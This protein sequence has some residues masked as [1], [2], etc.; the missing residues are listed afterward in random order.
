[1]LD[2]NSQTLNSFLSRPKRENRKGTIKKKK[3][4]KNT[5]MELTRHQRNSWSSATKILLPISTIHVEF[6]SYPWLAK[7]DTHVLWVC[8]VIKAVWRRSRCSHYNFTGV[9]HSMIDFLQ[10]LEHEIFL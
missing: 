6:S 4:K 10:E 3:K 8:P 1:M 5:V 9:H 7:E 2:E